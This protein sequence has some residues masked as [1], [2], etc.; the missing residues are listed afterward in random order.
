M[1]L[2]AGFSGWCLHGTREGADPMVIHRPPASFPVA[3]PAQGRT[4]A[5]QPRKQPAAASCCKP[6]ALVCW[7][8]ECSSAQ[9]RDGAGGGCPKGGVRLNGAV[10][11]G[12]MSVFTAKLALLFDLCR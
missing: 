1:H 6:G 12:Y 10:P 11:A 9:R 5:L 2:G 8:D 3:L 4:R 7:V